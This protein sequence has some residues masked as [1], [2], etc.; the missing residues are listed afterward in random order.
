MKQFFIIIFFLFWER[1]FRG[2]LLL[3]FTRQLLLHVFPTI[4]LGRIFSRLKFVF[5]FKHVPV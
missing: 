2:L 5:V 4:I 1:F 3:L